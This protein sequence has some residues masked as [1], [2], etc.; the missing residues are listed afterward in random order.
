MPFY[1]TRYDPHHR[2]YVRAEYALVCKECGGTDFGLSVA[3]LP[4]PEMSFKEVMSYVDA[5][6]CL[7]CMRVKGAKV[8]PVAGMH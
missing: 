6:M 2:S 8:E 4:H 3:I 1:T 7:A 5:V